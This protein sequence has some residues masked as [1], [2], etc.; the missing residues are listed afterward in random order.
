M[1]I[2]LIGFMKKHEYFGKQEFELEN[3]YLDFGDWNDSVEFAAAKS[4]EG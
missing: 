4:P 1:Q 3:D 2:E